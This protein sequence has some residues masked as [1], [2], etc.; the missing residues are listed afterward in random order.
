MT[1][2]GSGGMPLTPEEDA[3][4]ARLLAEAGGDLPMPES[5]SAR[6]DDVLEELQAERAVGATGA[7]ASTGST[8][9]VVELRARRRG[10][11]L[12]LAAAAVVVGGYAVG[13]VASQDLLSGDD[14]GDMAASDSAGGATEERL[15]D[16]DGARS[17]S[18]S[19]GGQSESGESEPGAPDSARSLRGVIRLRS[20]RFEAGA[21]RAVRTLDKAPAR[22]SFLDPED[23]CA[24][25]ELDAGER[26]L[27]VRYDGSAAVLVAGPEQDRTVEVTVYGCAGAELDSALVRP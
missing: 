25:P 18:D 5:V 11:R 23:R 8:G 26:S 9:D 13:T 12:L 3:A 16:R 27:P 14:G 17:Q 4:V 19:Q 24:P 20:D 21:V 15:A 2:G 22:L 6:L 7:A 10:S 1:E